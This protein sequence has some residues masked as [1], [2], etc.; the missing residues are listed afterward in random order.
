MEAARISTR[1]LQVRAIRCLSPPR[2]AAARGSQHPHPMPSPH[3][4]RPCPSGHAHQAMSWF[5]GLRPRRL[6]ASPAGDDFVGAGT[7]PGGSGCLRGRP[8]P[9]FTGG[10]MPSAPAV[11]PDPPC[12]GPRS[13]LLEPEPSS[14]SPGAGAHS[15]G[16]WF[17]PARSSTS[18]A[19]RSSAPDRAAHPQACSSE[20]PT[21][22][23]DSDT[24]WASPRCTG[25][26]RSAGA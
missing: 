24:R 2:A 10:A 19:S 26:P 17:H 4:M 14:G 25:P 7:W 6:V 8:G 11:D 23:A 12:A 20:A 1:R 16:S 18:A 21:E 3:E 5:L 22:V 13:A 9:R 15:A